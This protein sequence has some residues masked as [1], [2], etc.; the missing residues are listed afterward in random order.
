M[1]TEDAEVRAMPRK[2]TDRDARKRTLYKARG[3]RIL[4]SPLMAG[5]ILLTGAVVGV[6]LIF[7][8]LPDAAADLVVDLQQQVSEIF[9][10]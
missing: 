6:L 4:V 2:T 9:G 8:L 3:N 1:G 5:L 7:P 10:S